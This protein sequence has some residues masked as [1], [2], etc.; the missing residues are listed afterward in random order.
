MTYTVGTTRGRLREMIGDTDDDELF[1]DDQLDDVLSLTS[2]NVALAAAM[3]KRRLANSPGLLRKKYQDFGLMDVATM[4]TI[5][6]NL[7]DEADALEASTQSAFSTVDLSPD[8]DQ[9]DTGFCTDSDALHERT[10]LAQYLT[11][12]ETE[13]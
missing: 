5:Q 4:A 8:A 3:I 6:R 10:S 7:L 1:T 2:S 9:T 11:N 13:R 12:R